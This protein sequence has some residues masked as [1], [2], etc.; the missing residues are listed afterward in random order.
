MCVKHCKL[1]GGCKGV[2]KD[3][4]VSE[5]TSVANSPPLASSSSLSSPSQ[6]PPPPRF[7]TFTPSPPPRQHSL[8]HRAANSPRRSLSPTLA[9]RETTQPRLPSPP[10]QPPPL[11]NVVI[12]R[13]NPPPPL[14]STSG[15]APTSSQTARPETAPSQA[16]RPTSSSSQ[17]P[18]RIM[19]MPAVFTEARAKHQQEEAERRAQEQALQESQRLEIERVFVHVWPEVRC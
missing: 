7:A 4:F 17:A 12:F 16:P 3:H 11:N 18:R 13:V 9:G 8:F 10:V 6:S 14:A 5:E 15:A 2:G 1:A 19:H